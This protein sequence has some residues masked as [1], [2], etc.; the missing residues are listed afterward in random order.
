MRKVKH[1]AGALVFTVSG[2]ES[3]ESEAAAWAP[4]H[5]AIML[6]SFQFTL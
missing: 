5:P 6:V 4:V 2:H 3:Q 1:R